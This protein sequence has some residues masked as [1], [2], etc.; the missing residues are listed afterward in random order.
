[1]GNGQRIQLGKRKINTATTF[2]TVS[3]SS[4]A[5]KPAVSCAASYRTASCYVYADF[6]LI[7][8]SLSVLSQTISAFASSRLSSSPPPP[9]SSFPSSSQYHHHHHHHHHHNHHHHHHHHHHH[10]IVIN[11][12]NLIT[13][14]C[15]IGM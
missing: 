12:V 7:T 15:Q 3:T 10:Q 4:G 8:F 1:M 11:G 6:P 13:S 14:S 9:P 2:T 5:L